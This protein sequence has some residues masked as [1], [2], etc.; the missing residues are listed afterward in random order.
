ML[1]RAFSSVHPVDQLAPILRYPVRH[2]EA[3]P[4]C[5][6]FCPLRTRSARRKLRTD[7]VAPLGPV[8]PLPAP[9]QAPLFRSHRPGF[10]TCRAA[11]KV[12]RVAQAHESRARRTVA[13]SLPLHHVGPPSN[14]PDCVGGAPP[15][16][17]H[18]HHAFPPGF[19]LH[20]WPVVVVVIRR[21]PDFNAI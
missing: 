3:F 21:S 5:F 1:V 9:E 19:L 12:V 10:A 15:Y 6:Y 2:R 8:C 16:I 7:R 14:L 17:R 4:A 18:R 13:V 20:L 11:R